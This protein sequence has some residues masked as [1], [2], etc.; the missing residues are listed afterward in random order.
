MAGR[1]F[2]KGSI[3]A[4]EHMARLRAMRRPTVPRGPR[5]ST[6]RKGRFAKGSEEAKAHMARLRS[7]RKA[8]LSGLSI[9]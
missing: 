5:R 8:R 6:G 7:M 1:R 3:E 2:V 9:V 4:K